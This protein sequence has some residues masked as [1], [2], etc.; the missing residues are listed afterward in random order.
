V[1]LTVTDPTSG[2][3]D[4]GLPTA[5]ALSPN[6]PNPFNPATE[7]SFAVPRQGRVSLKIYDLAGRHVSTLIDGHKPA[8]YHSVMWNGTDDEGR[9]VASGAY[10]YRLQA[11]DYEQTRKMMLVK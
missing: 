4:G 5:F 8:G 3:G 6:H 11:Q 2:V 9:G 10:Y 1:S 7:I